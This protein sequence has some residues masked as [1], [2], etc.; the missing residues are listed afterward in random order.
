[1][2][3]CMRA[4]TCVRM[5]VCA[6]MCVCACMPHRVVVYEVNFRSTLPDQSS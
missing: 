3:A 5:R 4:C 2:R 6:R 1:M